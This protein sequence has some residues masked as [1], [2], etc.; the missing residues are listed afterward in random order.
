MIDQN[1]HEIVN[2]LHPFNL[3]AWSNYPYSPEKLIKR[4][5]TTW[6]PSARN[7]SFSFLS[8]PRQPNSLLSSTPLQNCLIRPCLSLLLVG[9]PHNFHTQKWKTAQPWEYYI[10]DSCHDI[11]TLAFFFFA[12]T[13][14]M[15]FF[16][17]NSEKEKEKNEPDSFLWIVLSWGNFKFLTIFSFRSF[18]LCLSPIIHYIDSWIKRSIIGM[19]KKYVSSFNSHL[20]L[21]V[22]VQVQVQCDSPTP[23]STTT[24]RAH[25]PTTYFGLVHHLPFFG[26]N[27][28]IKPISGQINCT[29]RL[30]AGL[31]IPP[32]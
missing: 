14:G 2:F 25:L 8:D 16:F 26:K 21:Y 11:E 9:L 31:E 10:I 28:T 12:R 6:V 29:F 7:R 19:H 23:T 3:S 17:S 30:E 27:S 15:F 32:L 18:S 22:Q 24:F 5:G 20:V 1:R 13:F 4:I